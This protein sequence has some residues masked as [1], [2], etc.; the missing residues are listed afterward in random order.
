VAGKPRPH[1]AVRGVRS[2]KFELKKGTLQE[3]VTKNNSGITS[4]TAADFGDKQVVS[5]HPNSTIFRE[6]P[7]TSACVPGTQGGMQK[8]SSKT[9]V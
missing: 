5:N 9:S 8:I 1:S 7:D 3:R 6:D 2:R 4:M